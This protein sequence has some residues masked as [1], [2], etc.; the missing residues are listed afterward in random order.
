MIERVGL[1]LCSGVDNTG[2][3]EMHEEPIAYGAPAAYFSTLPYEAMRQRLEEGGIPVRYSYH[4]GLY[5][6][7]YILYYALHLA[8]TSNPGMLAGFVHVP[9]LPEE[10]IKGM[11]LETT[12]RAL[13]F[14]TEEIAKAVNPAERES[15]KNKAEN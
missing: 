7:N 11:P 9:M 15:K 2:K 4:A 6:C 5:L 3:V 12:A 1:N 14:C 10:G 13:F 8:A